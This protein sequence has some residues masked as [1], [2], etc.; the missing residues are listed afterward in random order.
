M[1]RLFDKVY[2]S[3]ELLSEKVLVGESQ[4]LIKFL[5]ADTISAT[6][7][8]TVELKIEAPSTSRGG[9]P[10]VLIDWE[11]L[12]QDTDNK[13]V[14]YIEMDILSTESYDTVQGLLRITDT[15][16][17]TYSNTYNSFSIKVL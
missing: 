3:S 13:D 5:V 12:T 11:S 14:Y 9:D 7:V 16:G 8:S 6:E 17:N 4:N 2:F 15:N 10:V 1:K